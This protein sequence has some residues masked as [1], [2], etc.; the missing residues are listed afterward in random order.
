MDVADLQKQ[1]DGIA[2]E[3]REINLAIQSVNWTTDVPEHPI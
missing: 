2:Q 1:S 3:A